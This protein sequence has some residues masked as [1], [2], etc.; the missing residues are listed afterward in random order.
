MHWLDQDHVK[1]WWP[2]PKEGETVS[3]FI[4]GTRSGIVIPYVVILNGNPIG[5]IQTYTIDPSEYMKKYIANADSNA[6]TPMDFPETTLGMD[7]FIGEKDCIGKGLGTIMI[8]IYPI[9]KQDH[10]GIKKNDT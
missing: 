7:Q 10:T 3:A 6:L 4:K 1:A 9:S 5:Y 8:P 2:V